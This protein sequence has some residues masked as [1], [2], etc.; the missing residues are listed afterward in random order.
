MRG[1][2]AVFALALG[3]SLI[4]CGP[5]CMPSA[6]IQVTLVPSPSID[7][8]MLALL[9]IGLSV[10]GGPTHVLEF[11]PPHP[12]TGP[13]AFLLHPDQP[14]ASSYN[15]AVTVEAFNAA[16]ALVEVGG[17]SSQVSP[18]G[19]NRLEAR[20]APLP[21][22]GDG[23]T[24]GDAGP[25][26]DLLPMP[27]D[28]SCFGPD[29]DGDGRPNSCDLCPDDADPVPTDQDLDGLPDKCDP[30]IDRPGNQLVY[31]EPF[32]VS[33][34]H[35]SG[36]FQIQNSELAI[37]TQGSTVSANGLD[38]MPA[39]VRVQSHMLANGVFGMPST[40]VADIGLFLGS[41]PN[42]GGATTSGILCT[43]NHTP[44]QDTL[45]LNVVQNGAI[46]VPPISS[47]A[48]AFGTGIVYR[49][50]LVQHG[51]SYTCEA[52]TNGFP[53]T[54]ATATVSQAPSAPQYVAL[55][56]TNV[57]VRFHSVVAETVL[58]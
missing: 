44:S 29:E 54:T 58:P 35:W 30:D 34:G 13:S 23:S 47:Q 52:V 42:P 17:A 36:T 15:V 16:G 19:C 41:S 45:D 49:M 27:P 57:D 9:R 53:T 21:G 8:S 24:M 25:L 51:T 31:F 32:D 46:Q 11:T 7:A 50:R 38:V 2:A 55:H 33:N 20:L 28:L 39:N 14:P 1:P 37:Q 40:T 43:I 26:F 10:D 6:D 4:G 56:G 48:Y 18:S 22:A 12:L 5:D 3:A